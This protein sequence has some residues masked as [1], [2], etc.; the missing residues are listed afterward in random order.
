MRVALAPGSIH[1]RAA[2]GM[3]V[4]ETTPKSSTQLVFAIER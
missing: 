2:L 3:G 1:V 4:V